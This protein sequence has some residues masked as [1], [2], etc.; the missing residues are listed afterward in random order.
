MV[1]LVVPLIKF[2]TGAHD[3]CRFGKE[4]SRQRCQFDLDR[5]IAESGPD[6]P[7]IAGFVDLRFR[8]SRHVEKGHHREHSPSEFREFLFCEMDRLRL[9]ESKPG[10]RVKI[11]ISVLLDDLI[12]LIL[13]GVR[14]GNELLGDRFIM[15]IE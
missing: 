6:L 4:V 10:L 9:S 7:V 1:L 15:F 3:E 14:K 8:V 2:R 5:L 11:V 12:E 13:G